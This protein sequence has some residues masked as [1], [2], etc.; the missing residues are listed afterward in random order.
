MFHELG[1]AIHNLVA[2]TKY[3]IPYSR[4]FIEI[5]SIMLENWIWVPEA[6]VSLS[7]HQPFRQRSKGPPPTTSDPAEEQA[8][9][10]TEETLPLALAE[11]VCR[12]KAAD[13]AHN[14]LSQVQPALF[15]LAIHTP[16]DH[17]AACDMDTTALWH[18][19]RKDVLPYISYSSGKESGFGQGGFPHVFR[20]YDAGYFAYP[21]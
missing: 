21:L 2:R 16:A 10:Q 8:A 7:K 5:P 12:T 14:I 20:K 3:A 4:D 19:S 13:R 11:V 6:L 1:H 15:D 17:Q 18:Q 9:D